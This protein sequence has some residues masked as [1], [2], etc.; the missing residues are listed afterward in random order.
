MSAHPATQIFCREEE[1]ANGAWNEAV[2]A[3]LI[4]IVIGILNLYD[5]R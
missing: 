1:A 5:M 4:G 3:T 2:D